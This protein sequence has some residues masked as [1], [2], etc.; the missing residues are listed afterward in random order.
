MV[1]TSES[2]SKQQTAKRTESQTSITS[3]TRRQPS[4]KHSSSSSINSKSSNKVAAQV[5]HKATINRS[6]DSEAQ[7]NSQSQ[8]SRQR[9]E[10][11]SSP[12]PFEDTGYY[13]A[14]PQPMP[15]TPP[16]E[17]S[18]EKPAE[19]NIIDNPMAEIAAGNEWSTTDNQYTAPVD[20]NGYP[21]GYYN[22][23]NQNGVEQPDELNSANALDADQ[24]AAQDYYD[25]YTYTAEDGTVYYW[26]GQQWQYMYPER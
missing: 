10:S 16:D 8:K 1:I 24:Q 18:E 17:V 22:E 19:V 11:G 3:Q 13:I 2:F 6:Q 5:T 26:D 4:S 21:Y 14:E 20:A 15:P 23:N 12:L 25:N 7:I 9:N